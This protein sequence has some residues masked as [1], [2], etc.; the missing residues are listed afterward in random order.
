MSVFHCVYKSSA[1]VVI[2]LFSVELV[3]TK[4][5]RMSQK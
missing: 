1:Y 2:D 3:A 4:R 5:L